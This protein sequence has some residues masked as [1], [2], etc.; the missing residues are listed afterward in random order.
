MEGR[1]FFRVILTNT[2]TIKADNK[3]FRVFIVLMSEKERK[4][5]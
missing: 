3:G 1:C 2:D 5:I 4:T